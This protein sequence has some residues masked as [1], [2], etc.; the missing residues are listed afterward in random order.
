MTMHTHTYQNNNNKNIPAKKFGANTEGVE[1]THTYTHGHTMTDVNLSVVRSL[2]SFTVLMGWGL[3]LALTGLLCKL[4]SLSLEEVTSCGFEF[5]SSCSMLWLLRYGYTELVLETNEVFVPVDVKASCGYR[6][7]SD[8]SEPL[9]SGSEPLRAVMNPIHRKHVANKTI[10][11]TIPTAISAIP[12]P[13]RTL[14]S[15]LGS[16]DW[17]LVEVVA[18]I[19]RGHSSLSQYISLLS[20]HSGFLHLQRLSPRVPSVTHFPGFPLIRG[21][22]VHSTLHVPVLLSK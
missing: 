3:D 7:F 1:N 9:S 18:G 14:G 17:G 12:Q 21:Q 11:T 10:P 6:P 22:Y 13:G 20:W 2:A 8:A 16:S 4:D 5:L 19:V 15:M